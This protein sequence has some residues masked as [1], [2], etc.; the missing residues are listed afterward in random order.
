MRICSLRYSRAGLVANYTGGVWLGCYLFDHE[1]FQKQELKIINDSNEVRCCEK[2]LR[3]ERVNFKKVQVDD[4]VNNA[5]KFKK[6][7]YPYH[8]VKSAKSSSK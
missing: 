6:Y 4:M 1:K 2:R 5:T 3:L 8:Q 7:F